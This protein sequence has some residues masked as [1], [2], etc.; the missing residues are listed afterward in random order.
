MKPNFVYNEK[1]RPWTQKR[2]LMSDSGYGS[3]IDAANKLARGLSVV[4][5]FGKY[6]PGKK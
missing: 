3:R 6:G 5:V 4:D 2:Y 1:L